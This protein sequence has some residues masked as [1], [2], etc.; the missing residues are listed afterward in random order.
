MN[1]I[2]RDI[3]QL[4]NVPFNLE[5]LRWVYPSLSRI[6]QKAQALEQE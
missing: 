6:A 3:S 5:A 2:R 4:S 1:T